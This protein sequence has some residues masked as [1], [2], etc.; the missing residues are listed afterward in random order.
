MKQ[1]PRETLMQV[2]SDSEWVLM[3]DSLCCSRFVGSILQEGSEVADI[4][5]LVLLLC[6]NITGM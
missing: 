3:A 1:V 5:V 2:R 4:L 6:K